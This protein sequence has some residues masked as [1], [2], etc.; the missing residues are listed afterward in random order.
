MKAPSL[1]LAVAL[2]AALTA[3]NAL[4]D[5]LADAALPRGLA[6]A[7]GLAVT[8]GGV[9]WLGCARGTGRTLSE[10][11]WRRGGTVADALGATLALLGLVAAACAWL[12]GAEGL[13]GFVDALV[14]MS[15]RDR[16]FYAV[17]G[18]RNALVEESVFRG[19]LLP[20]LASRGP[21]VAVVGSAIVFALFHRSLDPLP[22]VM[23]TAFGLVLGAAT[24]R[25]GSL[26]PAAIAHA[27]LWA[28]V[29]DL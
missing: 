7:L 4:S 17:M 24:V 27:A 2:V 26:W 1:P 19:T 16:A 3:W 18:A 10:V 25:T 29:G 8:V 23:K 6:V 5:R 9:V 28:A 15:A 20:A 14:G 21:W 11:G 22:L 13:R 12:A